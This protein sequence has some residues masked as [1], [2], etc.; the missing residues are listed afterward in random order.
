MKNKG[1]TLIELMIVIAIIGVLFSIV[2]PP[3]MRHFEEQSS[4]PLANS[5][6]KR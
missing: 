3:I 4:K 5:E 1:F 6:G 2:M